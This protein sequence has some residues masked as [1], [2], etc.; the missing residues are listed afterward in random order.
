MPTKETPLSTPLKL[1]LGLL[2]LFTLGLRFYYFN[3]DLDA[4]RFYDERYGLENVGVFLKGEG[5]LSAYYPS[6]SFAP[7]TAV[8]WL[9]ETLHELTGVESL[10]VFDAKA[11]DGWSQQAYFLCRL[12]SAL[13]GVISVGLLFRI[14]YLCFSPSVGLMAAV[15]FS[16]V[17]RHLL[18]SSHFKPDILV[19]LLT[20]MA[21]LKI[22]R[23]AFEPTKAQFR[24]A[25]AS[26]GLAVAAKYT[27]VGIAMS[28][29]PAALW[30]GFR[31]W[32]RWRL[33]VSA[34]LAS[35][36]TFFILN[37]HVAT[38][39]KYLGR[40]Q[41]IAE[42]KG[43]AEGGSHWTVAVDSTLFLVEQHGRWIFALAMAG[44]VAWIWQLLSNS[45]FSE[46]R[47][48]EKRDLA[49]LLTYPL[50]YSALWIFGTTVF[51]GQ[52]HLPVTAFT[53]L[54]AA[55]TIV[56]LSQKL[57]SMGILPRRWGIGS[58]LGILALAAISYPVR[59]A[60]EGVVPSTFELVEA[61]VARELTP[62][63]QRLA[64]YEEGDYTWRLWK[65]GRRMARI[66]VPSLLDLTSEDLL[67]ADLALFLAEKMGGPLGSPYKELLKEGTLEIVKP[68]L[69]KAHGPEIAI[70]RSPWQ[71]ENAC[72]TLDLSPTPTGPESV[73]L[74]VPLQEGQT[75]S[76][77][78][79]IPT[80]PRGTRPRFVVVDGKE[81]PL[82]RTR[83][84]GR[85]SHFLTPRRT[86]F[87]PK[88]A[89]SLGFEPFPTHWPKPPIVELC[90]WR[91]GQP[92]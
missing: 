34:A 76:I 4:S 60:Y 49:L 73:S 63:H 18:S 59:L 19:A 91:Q 89:L 16:A 67:K 21:F 25:G 50:G 83:K 80:Y 37:P 66:Q 10:S 58:F 7:Q 54:A 9:S 71:L 13:F 61:K 57:S 6:L 44:F 65:E 86:T 53:S 70:W 2:L 82:L 41:R 24:W 74:E 15:F 22:R 51:R 56:A 77:S 39:F 62:H 5:K 52:N 11:S 8:L 64:Y 68:I 85:R 38:I 72:E 92:L 31:Q 48:Q 69:G 90:R 42:S 23:A 36:V 30:G 20:L 55:W 12:L 81:L 27:G 28:V 33:L 46:G 75:T 26:V 84:R 32:K 43:E 35:V 45:E 29:V 17:P 40:L 1:A 79:W 87:E 78:A 3:H 14:G 47:S 88:E